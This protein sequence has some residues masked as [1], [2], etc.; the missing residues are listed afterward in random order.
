VQPGATVAVSGHVQADAQGA[1]QIIAD[2]VR[3]K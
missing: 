3:I 1:L 2:R